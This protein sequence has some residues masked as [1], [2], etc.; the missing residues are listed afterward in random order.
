M[1]ICRVLNESAKSIEAVVRVDVE[2]SADLDVMAKLLDGKIGHFGYTA[3]LIK[4][5]DPEPAYHEKLHF[6]KPDGVSVEG[7]FGYSQKPG[8]GDVRYYT[9]RVNRD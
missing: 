5:G 9:V 7:Q 2:E 1:K 8:L 6:G 4:V 3:C